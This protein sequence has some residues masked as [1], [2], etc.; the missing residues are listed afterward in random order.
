MEI[1][2]VS[3]KDL[4]K[5]VVKIA[6]EI[7]KEHYAQIISL[8]QI[9]F[10]LDKFQSLN[11]IS[12]QINKEH[13]KYFLIKDEAE[14]PVGYFAI[15]PKPDHLFLSK[16]YIKQNS[17]QK[18]YGKKVISFITDFAKQNHLPHISLTVNRQNK[19]SITAYLKMGFQI[20]SQA[21]AEIGNN[22]IMND[23]IM[24]LNLEK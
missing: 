11:A 15:V 5:T 23:Y 2:E 22:F 8:E 19:N 20:I 3:S 14:N 13:Y 4:I 18:G 24:Q 12:T 21:N 17:R 9:E 10:M 16:F 1:V 7:W 6:D